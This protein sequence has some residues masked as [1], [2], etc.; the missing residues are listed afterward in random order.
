[1]AGEI[2]EKELSFQIMQA[3]YEV[4]NRLGPGF[5]ENI[6]E[7]AL[8][9]E[10]RMRGYHVETQRRIPVLYKDQKIGEHVLDL[11]VNGRV[12]LELKAAAEITPIHKQQAISYLR[13]ACLPLAIVINFGAQRVQAARLVN[14]EKK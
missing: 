7:E 12:I 10:L 1:V 5:L 4:F 2:V 14:T 3:A 6:Y 9:F 8:A 13:A 11:V